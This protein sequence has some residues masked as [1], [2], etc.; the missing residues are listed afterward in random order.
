LVELLKKL[1]QDER[2][3]VVL[4]SGRTADELGPWFGHL[5]INLVAEHGAAFKKA[6]RSTW[7]TI[8]KVD[9]KWKK[10]LLPQLEKYAARTP[11][12]H[13]EV[14]PHSLVWH[15]RA[16][17]AYYAQKN[18]VTIKRVFKP[19]L[20]Q[21]GLEMMQGSK[22]LE[23]KN[24]R[25]SKGSAAGDWLERDYD[26]VFFVGDDATDEELFKVL[27]PSAYSIKV[28]RG[29]TAARF[30]VSGTNDVLKLLKTMGSKQ[31]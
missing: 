5:P 18:T 16:S 19:L 9:T 31:A 7:S 27:P 21:H 10:V 14:K 13:V 11:K 8:E 24:P 4:I 6:G 2:N 3:D 25:I 15:Y 17:P 28:G 26:F 30:R 20:K 1:G 29:R 23:I 12:A 22:A